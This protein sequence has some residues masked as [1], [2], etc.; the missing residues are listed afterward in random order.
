MQKKNNLA[1]CLLLFLFTAGMLMGSLY[2][3]NID[4]QTEMYEYLKGGVQGYNVGILGS[5]K[6]VCRDDVAELCILLVSAFLPF[7]VILAGGV[8]AFRG[9]MTGFALTAALRAYGIGGILL[10]LG[11][12]ASALVVVPC[13]M[14]Y[15]IFILSSS[16]TKSRVKLF[17]FCAVFLI[18][19][20]LLDSVLK[21]AL[22]VIMSRLWR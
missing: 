22:S 3:V 10:C 18:I 6:A 17:F 9:F 1:L 8:L 11:N 16:Y 20:F 19:L 13:V 15:G 7:G 12:I 5:I 4:E 2:Q 21:G 14:L